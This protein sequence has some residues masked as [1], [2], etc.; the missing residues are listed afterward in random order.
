MRLGLQPSIT[1]TLLIN[2]MSLFPNTEVNDLIFYTG[3]CTVSYKVFQSL[4]GS[5]KVVSR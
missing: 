5:N 4:K 2:K 3:R 1:K